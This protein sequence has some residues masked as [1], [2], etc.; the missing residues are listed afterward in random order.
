MNEMVAVGGSIAFPT[1]AAVNS[2]P[3]RPGMPYELSL[4]QFL[5]LPG[6]DSLFRRRDQIFR[7]QSE[8]Y[9]FGQ[10]TKMDVTTGPQPIHLFT[11]G[12]YTRQLTMPAGLVIVSKRH[13]RE[14]I[15]LISKGSAT[16]FTEDGVTRLVAPFMFVS[17]AGAK[18]A[19]CVHEETTWTTIHRTNATSLD[20]VELDVMMDEPES[21]WHT[22][23][24]L[25]NESKGKAP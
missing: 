22:T 14:H 8:I 12:I 18:R 19:L 13:A 5:D 15:V 21:L 10:A 2:Y 11:R 20:G 16:V 24:Q 9:D 17:P 25:S 4:R 1:D 7:L 3:V 6:N 23:Q